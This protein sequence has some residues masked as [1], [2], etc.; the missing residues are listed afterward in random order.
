MRIALIVLSPIAIGPA[1]LVGQSVAIGPTLSGLRVGLGAL[2]SPS[3]SDVVELKPKSSTAMGFLRRETAGWV[4]GGV[5]GGV[6]GAAIFAGIT[7]LFDGVDHRGDAPYL[8]MA[9][10]GAVAGFVIG[11]LIAGN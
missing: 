2:S 1:Q 4:K 10:S 9:F 5:V 8:T 11:A 3:G 6:A 7:Y